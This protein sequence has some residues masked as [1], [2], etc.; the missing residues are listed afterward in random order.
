M[1]PPK[2]PEIGNV[3]PERAPKECP[4]KD[5]VSPE[6]QVMCPPKDQYLGI[7]TRLLGLY[8]TLTL[9]V[10]DDTNSS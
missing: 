4:P 9:M 2:D 7:V 3:S 8:F 10:V 6:R 5:R 1:C